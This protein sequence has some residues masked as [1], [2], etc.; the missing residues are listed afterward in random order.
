MIEPQAMSSSDTPD[1]M[2]ETQERHHTENNHVSSFDHQV[3]GQ[4]LILRYDPTTIC[5]CLV[6]REYVFYQHMPDALRPHV[7]TF[8]G[9]TPVKI[10]IGEASQE[11]GSLQHNTRGFKVDPS[12]YRA[13]QKTDRI[14]NNEDEEIYQFMKLEDLMYP[15]RQP[16]ILDLKVGV[17]QHGDDAPQEKVDYQTQKCLNTTSHSLGLRL[18]GMK[19]YLIREQTYEKKDKFYGRQIGDDELKNEII[20]FLHNGEEYRFDLVDPIISQLQKLEAVIRTLEGYRFYSCSLVIIYDGEIENNAVG[21]SVD[22]NSMNNNVPEVPPQQTS[23][24]NSVN[25]LVKARIVD[26]AHATYDGFEKDS[27][28]HIGPDHGFLLGLSTLLEVFNEFKK[29]SL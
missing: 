28:R 9:T 18:C 17:R 8:K 5:K 20:N 6:H 4:S 27:V 21:D 11:N 10:S 3:A 7:A 25:D 16:C 24:A 23:N 2:P 12:R 13:L 15:Y 1:K 19:R 26:F 29:Q 14:Y 22:P